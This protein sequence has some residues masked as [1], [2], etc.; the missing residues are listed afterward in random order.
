MSTRSLFRAVVAAIVLTGCV[1]N[2]NVAPPSSAPQS[3]NDNLIVP[4]QRIGKVYLGMP[5]AQLYKEFGNPSKRDVADGNAVEYTY[6][7]ASLTVGVAGGKVIDVATT[8]SLFRTANGVGVGS[9]D[10]EVR[11]KLGPPESGRRL[12]K[13][14]ARLIYDAAEPNAFSNGKWWLNENAQGIVISIL[15]E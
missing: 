7:R 8:S 13:S 2:N 15:V 14:R 1:T 6:D 9:S 5:I 3:F 4:G 10:I 11:S 12:P